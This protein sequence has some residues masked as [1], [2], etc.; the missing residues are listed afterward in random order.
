VVKEADPPLVSNSQSRIVIKDVSDDSDDGIGPMPAVEAPT[1][2]ANPKIYG[3]ALRPGEGSAMAAFVSE[4]QRIPRRGEIGLE[5]TQIEAFEKAGYVMSGSRHRKMNAVRIR[6]ENQVITAEEK[7]SLMKMQQEE[8]SK[9]EQAIVSS[10]RE[11]T[12]FFIY[13]PLLVSIFHPSHQRQVADIWGRAACLMQLIAPSKFNK[14]QKRFWACS[15]YACFL[16]FSVCTGM[17]ECVQ[18][19]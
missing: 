3:E 7:R 5:S 12:S 18:C 1:K 6:K 2:A 17:E 4:G 11:R 8:K 14:Q 15:I 10:F 13:N 19:I 9:R 16:Q